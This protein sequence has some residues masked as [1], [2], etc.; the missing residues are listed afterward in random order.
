MWESL[1]QV[2]SCNISFRNKILGLNK[3]SNEVIID[4]SKDFASKYFQLPTGIVMEK[5]FY[6]LF[7]TAAYKSS[8]KT[9]FI[10]EN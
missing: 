10:H 3:S 1:F 5:L 6:E 9:T 7:S 2:A 4:F 8:I